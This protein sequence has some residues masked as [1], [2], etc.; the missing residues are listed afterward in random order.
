MK[1]HI[2]P[3]SPA[4]TAYEFR[5]PDGARASGGSQSFRTVHLHGALLPCAFIGGIGTVPEHR[6]GGLVREMVT[7]MAAE[8]DRRSVP[9]TLLHP[10]SFA[11]YRKFGFERVADHRVLEFPMSALDV[12]PRCPDL[13]P[14][15][16]TAYAETLSALYNTFAK[17]RNLLPSRGPDH[18][19]PDGSGPAKVYLSC[20]GEGK[21]DGYILYDME[22]YFWVN[23]M[24]SVNLHV[25]E[26]VFTTPAAL[27][28][29]FGFMRMFEGELDTVMIHDCAMMPE[30]ELR[31]RHYM[32]TKITV[33]PDLMARVNDVA[34]VLTAIRY[35][36]APGSF[37]VRT[38]EPDGTPWSPLAHKTTGTFRVDY[39][40][41]RGRVTRLEDTADYDLAA[42]IPAFTQLIFGYESC[43]Y[44]TARYTPGTEFRTPAADFFRAFPRL[45]GGVFEHF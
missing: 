36:V 44:E 9:L 28:R 19:Y 1:L 14:C 20:D 37:T 21:P 11:Y 43:G 31:L 16:G 8:S 22:K 6:R 45:P 39:A 17:G 10:F 7:A 5:T 27:D 35:P 29:L 38:T 15:R 41:G 25:R 4:S 26:L 24:V 42:D 3:T 18:P 32:H 30:V 12:F 40:D 34:A 23:R 33:I 13:V 2:Q